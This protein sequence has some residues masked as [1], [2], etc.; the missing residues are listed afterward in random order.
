MLASLTI[1]GLS[2]CFRRNQQCWPI[3]VSALSW[4]LRLFS[5]SQH[6]CQRRRSG[7]TTHTSALNGPYSPPMSS[8]H[9]HLLAFPF[10]YFHIYHHSRASAGQTRTVRSSTAEFLFMFSLVEAQNTFQY[11]F[12]SATLVLRSLAF[13]YVGF[14]WVW[15]S[16]WVRTWSFCVWALIFSGWTFPLPRPQSIKNDR[17][18]WTKKENRGLFPLNVTVWLLYTPPLNSSER[19]L[20][21]LRSLLVRGIVLPATEETFTCFWLA[22]RILLRR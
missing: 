16:S 17:R 8:F 18:R 3:W 13:S 21:Q 6:L 19:I 12:I 20:G 5:S 22:Q 7:H 9:Q 1:S 11:I 4:V 2:T 10:F 15:G 14:E